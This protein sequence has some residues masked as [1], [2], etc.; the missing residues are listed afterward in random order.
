MPKKESEMQMQ[1]SGE[2]LSLTKEIQKL[3]ALGIREIII[4]SRKVCQ[5]GV[6]RG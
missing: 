1:S 6:L 2:W 5:T 4:G 3:S